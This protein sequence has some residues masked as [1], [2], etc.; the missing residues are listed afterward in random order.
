MFGV[1]NGD[2]GGVSIEIVAGNMVGSM[3]ES[4]I[5]GLTKSFSLI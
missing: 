2:I 4:S 5:S 3:S 1:G